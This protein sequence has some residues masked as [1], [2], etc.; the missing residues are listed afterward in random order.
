MT[1][2][3]IWLSHSI[4]EKTISPRSENTNNHLTATQHF[5]L[6]SQHKRWKFST[7]INAESNHAKWKLETFFLL[8][9]QTC[10]R[11]RFTRHNLSFTRVSPPI[12]DDEQRHYT[13]SHR[14]TLSFHL[15]AIRKINNAH[16]RA[17][18]GAEIE[19]SKPHSWKIYYVSLWYD[20][21]RWLKWSTLQEGNNRPTEF[22]N[23]PHD[24]TRSTTTTTTLREIAFTDELPIRRRRRSALSNVSH[25]HHCLCLRLHSPPAPSRDRVAGRVLRVTISRNGWVEG[26]IRRQ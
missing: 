14:S 18:P 26:G 2:T 20:P 7:T 3:R 10:R 25:T 5:W 24:S 23:S 8:S 12:V 19:T 17:L 6:S 16:S 21:P 4:E 22:T 1:S 9:F 13:Q 11:Y 15:A